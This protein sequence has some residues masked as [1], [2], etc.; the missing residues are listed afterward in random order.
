MGHVARKF[1]LRTQAFTQSGQHRVNGQP[2]AFDIPR[3]G[4][5]SDGRRQRLQI[6]RVAAVDRALQL[7]QRPQITLNHPA[8]PPDQ[9][10]QKQPL[11]HHGIG[12][13]AVQQA[14]A[15]G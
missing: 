11:G 7:G 12:Q 15:A 13:H 14:V 6:F 5:E 2:Q 4:I 1:A 10:Q 3:A 9:Q 8:Q